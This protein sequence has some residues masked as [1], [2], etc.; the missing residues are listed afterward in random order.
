MAKPLT[1]K[2]IA[3]I[4][5]SGKLQIIPDYDELRSIAGVNLSEARC[6]RIAGRLV[7]ET[8][9]VRKKYVDYLNKTGNDTV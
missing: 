9:R 3:Y 8:E 1:D 6:T 4:Y 7:T 2:Q 5:L